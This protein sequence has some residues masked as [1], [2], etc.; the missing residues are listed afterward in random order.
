MIPLIRSTTVLGLRH[1][2]ATVLG[3]DGQVTVGQTV[4][5]HRA[6]K[7]RR[8]YNNTVL[9]GFAG[10]AADAFTLFSK[11]ED[12]LEKHQGN[13]E[14]AAVELALQGRNAVMPVIVRTSDD[15]Y[16]W[17]V[18][19][20]SLGDVAN[21]EKKMPSEYISDDGFGITEACRRYLQPLIQGESY[22]PYKHGMPDYVTLRNEPGAKKLNTDFAL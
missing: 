2:G 14:R 9:A 8:L 1:R 21:V 7:V 6:R 19:T 20:A 22:P 10:A 12:Y 15:P 3:A 4:M 5:K 17:E 18:G 16:E 13:L 11:F